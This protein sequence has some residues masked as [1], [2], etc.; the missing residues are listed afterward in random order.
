MN[1]ASCTGYLVKD[2]SV[3]YTPKGERKLVFET[4]IRADGDTTATP[5]HCEMAD[6]PQLDLL[7]PLLTPGQGVTLEAQIAGRPF[8][9]DGRQVGYN[10]FLRITKIT[11]ARMPQAA[12]PAESF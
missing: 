5:W 11:P 8:H 12:E 3:A 6:S 2:A 10:R 9:K 4:F 1:T 7:A